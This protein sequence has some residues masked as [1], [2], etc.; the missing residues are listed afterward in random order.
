[1]D[2]PDY[3]ISWILVFMFLLA[4]LALYFAINNIIDYKQISIFR[5]IL[6]IIWV[7]LGPLLILGPIIE[8][9][10]FIKAFKT[11]LAYCS[12][13][14]YME[15]IQEEGKSPIIRFRF[16]FFLIPITQLKISSEM[17]TE[18]ECSSGQGRGDGNH[19]HITLNYKHSKIFSKSKIMVDAFFFVTP[20]ASKNKTLSLANKLFDFLISNEVNIRKKKF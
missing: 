19:W 3:E 4:L 8:S 20:D 17:L 9:G 15:V 16:R 2:L 13:N 1:M 6:A 11:F 12:F 18:I 14:R 10:G 5:L 7:I